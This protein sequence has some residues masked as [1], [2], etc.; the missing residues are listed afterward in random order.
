MSK[1]FVLVLLSARRIFHL[2]KLEDVAELFSK[3]RLVVRKALRCQE[4]NL[5]AR[6]VNRVGAQDLLNKVNSRA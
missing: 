4:D 1:A 3:S 2:Q 5:R 6:V